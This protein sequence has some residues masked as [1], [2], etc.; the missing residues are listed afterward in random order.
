[1]R[2][3]LGMDVPQITLPVAAGRS[4]AVLIE[5]AARNHILFLKGYDASEHFMLNQQSLIDRDDA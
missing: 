4:L 2:K 5:T 1:M 3:V